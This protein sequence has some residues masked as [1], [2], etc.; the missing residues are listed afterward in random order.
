MFSRGHTNLTRSDY[1]YWLYTFHELGIY[2][3][4]SAL[5]LVAQ[6]SGK[7]KSIYI[8]Y[9]MGTTAMFVY[10]SLYPT[11]AS[12]RLAGVIAIAPVANLTGIRCFLKYLSPFW[13]HPIKPIAKLLFNG[14]FVP[15]VDIIYRF[16]AN[17]PITMFFCYAFISLVTGPN[18]KDLD[19]LYRPVADINIPEDIAANVIDHYQQCYERKRFLQ[20]DHGVQENLRR[21]GNEI[22]PDYPIEDIRTPISFFVSDNDWI[23]E[24]HNALQTYN[25]ISSEYQ[26]GYD[27][28]SNKDFGHGDVMTSRYV[29]RDLNQ[30]VLSKVQQMESSL[31]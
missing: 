17:G 13:R 30:A 21:Y 18:F 9:S 20:Y 16:C 8:G 10:S 12:E 19:P 15:K 28:S 24:E 5:D 7:P 11:E 26:C 27:V 1:A 22:P 6:I 4:P 14:I 2:D 25:Q 31:C 29:F 23:A 3:I